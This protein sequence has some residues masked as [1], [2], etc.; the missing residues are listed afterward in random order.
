[1]SEFCIFERI[2]CI[3]PNQKYEAFVTAAQMGSFKKAA[4][5]LGYTQAGISYMMNALEEEMGTA[6]FI[7]D[8]AGVR[9]TADGQ[10]LLPWIQ[11]VRASEQAL[12][13]HLDEIRDSEVG[14]VR[15]ATF[16]SVAIHWLPSI[17][18][19]FLEVHPKMDFEFSC[20]E[21][22][23][24]MEEAIW[25]GQFD[26]GFV[27]LPVKSRFH[28][29]PLMTEPI[30]AVVAPDHPLA[31][32][33]TFPSSSLG[34]EPY[35]KLFNDSYTEY[36]VIFKLN[37][38]T[39]NT[40]FVVDNDFAVLGMVS[41]GLG[42]SLFPRLILQETSFALAWLQPEVP[43]HRELA[44]AVRSM[45][46]ASIATKAFLQFAQEWVRNNEG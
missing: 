44:L 9:L 15:V 7:R 36:D 35:I 34:S 30:Y 31:R 38:V 5:K 19:E 42:Y 20:F 46:K 10:N 21:N 24:L 26:C 16:A 25:N 14:T 33:R 39:P 43:L 6:L 17:I 23:D 41:K 18:S 3:M 27:T 29:I 1:M 13:T 11:D 28:T 45:D 12:Q 32:S 4:E 40:R 8:R 22:Q 2:F 37:G